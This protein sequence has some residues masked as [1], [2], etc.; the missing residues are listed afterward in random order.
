M[1]ENIPNCVVFG[2]REPDVV[3]VYIEMSLYRPKAMHAHCA[4]P[5]EVLRI[6]DVS[7]A[8]HHHQRKWV[9]K[10]DFPSWHEQAALE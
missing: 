1:D 8:H 7:A 9:S 3:G 4:V 6:T 10:V 2:L 5:Y